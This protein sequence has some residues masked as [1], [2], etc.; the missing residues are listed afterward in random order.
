M[1]TPHRDFR[2]LPESTQAE[3]RRQAFRSLDKGH[4]RRTVADNAEVHVKTIAKWISR[5]ATL[6]KKDYYGQKRGRPPGT[7]KFI[8]P[9]DEKRIRNLIETKTPDKVGL[10]YALWTRKAIQQLIKKKLRETLTLRTISKYTKRWGLTPQRPAKYAYEQDGEAIR[11]WLTE[12]YPAIV[13]KAKKENA[14]IHWEDE[15]GVSLSTFYARSYAPKGKTPAIKLPARRASLSM[16]SSIMNR[17]DLRFMLYSGA[18]NSSLFITF[19]KR[20]VKDSDRKIFL[21]LDNLRVHKSK[22]VVAWVVRHKNQ[23]EL[24]SPTTIRSAVQSR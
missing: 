22:K 5:R 20:L 3:V 4:D 12:T 19:L 16:I 11:V 2:S 21:I 1:K 17:G 10:P 24:F 14:D 23:I 8:Q 6:E 13:K 18:L 9:K 7:Q 15:T